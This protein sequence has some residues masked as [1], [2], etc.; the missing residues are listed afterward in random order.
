MAQDFALP[1]NTFTVSL[2]DLIIG[3]CSFEVEFSTCTVPFEFKNLTT[4]IVSLSFSPKI[5]RSPK[6]LGISDDTRNLG[7]GLKSISLS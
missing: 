7:F 5:I 4:N 6:D 3:T 2:N 1:S